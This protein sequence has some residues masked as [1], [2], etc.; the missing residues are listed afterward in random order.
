MHGLDIA[1]GTLTFADRAPN[2]LM[3]AST[4]NSPRMPIDG[5]EPSGQRNFGCSGA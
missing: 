5:Q 3:H 4:S 1:E 2:R